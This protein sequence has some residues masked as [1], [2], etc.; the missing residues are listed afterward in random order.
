[1]STKKDNMVSTQNIWCWNSDFWRI[2]RHPA[3]WK[4]SCHHIYI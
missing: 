2:M 1:M 4:F 3:C